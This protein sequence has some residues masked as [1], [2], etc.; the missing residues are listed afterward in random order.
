MRLVILT[1]L[2]VATWSG[3]A[4]ADYA[5]GSGGVGGCCF[6]PP[7]Q[8]DARKLFGE[9]K[10][11]ESDDLNVMRSNPAFCET[12]LE[13]CY[14]LSND[15]AR[16]IANN[17]LDERRFAENL[18]VTRDSALNALAEAKG[19]NNLAL[20]SLLIAMATFSLI[21]FRAFKR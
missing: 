9:L 17:I 4:V 18:K 3:V 10:K 14:G 11:F 1:L 15:E 8:V 5:G 12:H 6:G 19:A 21:L 7:I 16:N 2:Y 20:I 13:K